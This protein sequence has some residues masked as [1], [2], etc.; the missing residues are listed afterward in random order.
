MVLYPLGMERFL[1]ASR[2]RQT[3]ARPIGQL[4][5]GLLP[6]RFATYVR[7]PPSERLFLFSVFRLSVDV[8]S[9]PSR[10]SIVG[11]LY[12]VT[13]ACVVCL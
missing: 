2:P 11:T 9:R 8:R 10:Y 12:T 1:T 13:P 3:M 4:L 5:A 6:R 7:T